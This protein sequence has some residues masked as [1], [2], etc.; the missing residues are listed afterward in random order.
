MADAAAVA[1]E[2]K[3]CVDSLVE[4]QA[5]IDTKRNECAKV[6]GLTESASACE[7]SKRDGEVKFKIRRK[8]VP[9]AKVSDLCWWPLDNE[10][11]CSVL[12]DGKIIIW[13]AKTGQKAYFLC[14]NT[15]LMSGDFSHDG[16]NL[17]VAGLDNLVTIHKIPDLTQSGNFDPAPAASDQ[18]IKQMEKHG[19]YIGSV[20]WLDDQYVISGSGDKT[21]MLWDVSIDKGVQKDPHSTFIGHGLSG[22]DTGDVAALDAFKGETNTFIS[23]ASDGYAK[24]WDRRM[25]NSSGNCCAMTF[26][27]HTDNINKIKYF[28]SGKSF[29]TASEDGTFKVFD[30]R[31]AQEMHSFETEDKATSVTVSKSGRYLFGGCNNGQIKA[32]DLLNPDAVKQDMEFH[33]AAVTSI[34][35]ANDGKAIASCSREATTNM[36]IWA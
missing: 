7:E 32:Y 3:T 11:I 4:L 14:Q 28:P 30:L 35:L 31:L 36:A 1:A 27:G 13:N 18:K 34:E 23:G 12:Q 26:S 25:D 10:H 33:N 19:G 20:K 21:I 17:A 15:W 9:D 5:E 6:D 16:K 22:E 24:L 2:L 8:F 29:V